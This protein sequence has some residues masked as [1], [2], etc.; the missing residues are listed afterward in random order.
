M[1]PNTCKYFPFPKIAFL[2][3]KYFPKNILHEPNTTLVSSFEAI[4]HKLL[5][6]F[7]VLINFDFFVGLEFLWGHKVGV[8]FFV[9]ICHKG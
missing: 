9:V 2:E 6:I 1:Q 8:W 5:E 4:L 3:N 7:L